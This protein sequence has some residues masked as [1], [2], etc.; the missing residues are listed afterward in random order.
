MPPRRTLDPNRLNKNVPL[1]MV[2]QA[3]TATG[4][5]A[6]APAS[7]AENATVAAAQVV[8]PAA[9]RTGRGG[10]PALPV[11]THGIIR[12]YPNGKGGWRAQTTYRDIDGRTRDVERHASTKTKATNKLREALKNRKY[13][14]AHLAE[15]TPD[16]KLHHLAEVWYQWIVGEGKAYRTLESYRSRID[17]QII[18]GVGELRIRE[19]TVQLL[20][21]FIARVK[22]RHGKTSAKVTRT[23]LSGMLGLAARYGAIDHNP[24]RDVAT[25]AIKAAPVRALTLEEALDLRSR[26]HGDPKAEARDIIDLTDAMLA[27]GERIG[28]TSA[29]TRDCLDLD[30]DTLTGTVEIKGTV[31]R[32]KGHGLVIESPKSDAGYRTHELPWWAVK[33]FL[34]RI[35][36]RDYQPTDPIFPNIETGIGLRDP[37]NTSDYLGDAFD[38]AGYEWVTSQVYRKTVAT[39]HGRRRILR[40]PDRRPRRHRPTIGGRRPATGLGH[41]RTRRCAWTP[42]VQPDPQRDREVAQMSCGVGGLA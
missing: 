41:R 17:N 35:N 37:S 25:I 22:D 7:E 39:P 16:T 28:E 14:A 13:V 5:S 12:T 2:F 40:T 11:G 26:I 4:A 18:P 3:P 36:E 10:R 15:V 6:P 30:E 20:D 27:T 19:A 8:P 42:I 21:Q 29:I 23:C 38:D 33:M 32:I 31:I 9:P 34:R 1:A 24:V